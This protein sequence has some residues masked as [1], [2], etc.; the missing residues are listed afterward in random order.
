[1]DW[2]NERY[3]RVYTRDTVS[4]KLCDWRAHTTLLHLFRKVDRAGVLDVGDDGTAGLAAVLELPNEVVGPGIEQL[5][6]AS[7]SGRSP[8]VAYTGS[9][10]VILNFIEA[11]EAPQSDPQRARESRAR[12]RDV[13][14]LESRNVSEESRN[15]S[16][17][18]RGVTPCHEASRGVTPSQTRPDQTKDM[19][20]KPD[21]GLAFAEKAIALINRHAGTRY[22]PD[23][24]AVRKLVKALIR[25]RH[26]PEQA[27]KVIESKRAWI[28]DPKMGEFFRPATLLA[29]T[30]FATYLDDLEAGP[31]AAQGALRMSSHDD[32]EPDLT[33]A[34]CGMSIGG[35]P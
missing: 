14:A 5:T 4:W 22:Q 32:D 1:M 17:P 31:K 25:N 28:G 18:S 26:T 20:G 16:E 10:Y 9:S 7:A 24:T 21:A 6:R 2:A 27:E 34:G 19:S 33:Y 13:A 3:V 8:T 29:A 30:N 15:V 12:R 11:Q 23:S 35:A